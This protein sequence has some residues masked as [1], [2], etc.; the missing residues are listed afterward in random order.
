MA[1]ELFPLLKRLKVGSYDNCVIL[2]YTAD[3]YFFEQVVL[4]TLRSR[5]SCNNLV[6]MDSRQYVSALDTSGTLLRRLGKS[7]SVWPVPAAQAFHPKLLLQTSE[8]QARLIVGSGNLTVRGFSTNWELFSEIAFN[9]ESENGGLF[10]EAWKLISESAKDTTTAVRRQLDRMQTTSGSALSS[11]GG[12]TWPRLLFAAPS[13]PS[14]LNQL[15]ALIGKAKV[16][17]LIIV[18]PFFDPKLQAVREFKSAFGVK[19]VLAIVQPESVSFPGKMAKT[20][21]NLAVHEFVP[22]LGTKSGYLHAK[23]FV[24]QTPTTEYTVWGSANCSMSALAGRGNYEAVLVTR[25]KVGDGV[26]TLGLG[27]SIK[28]GRKI[29]PA[30]LELAATQS[31][32][33]DDVLSLTSA[34]VDQGSIRVVISPTDRF[35]KCDDGRLRLRSE[36][37]PLGEIPVRRADDV[38]FTGRLNR[39]EGGSVICRFVLQDE[40]GE[41]E[42]TPVAVHFLQDLEE[43]TPTRLQA[44]MQR[45]VKA[46]QLGTFEWAKGLESVCELVIKIGLHTD[47]ERPTGKNRAQ[48]AKKQASPTDTD[49]EAK[50][51]EYEDFVS[52]ADDDRRKEKEVESQNA[53][54]DIVS[55]LRAQILRGV[56]NEDDEEGEV[57]DPDAWRYREEAEREAAESGA[58]ETQH[59]LPDSEALEK[60]HLRVRRGY[61]Q[62]VRGLTRRYEWLRDYKEAV[63]TEEFWRLDAVNLLLLDGCG[64]YIERAQDLGAV[65]LPEDVIKQYLPAAAVFLGRVRELRDSSDGNGPLLDRAKIE[66]SDAGIRNALRTS[67]A[68][69]TGVVAH[70]RQLLMQPT[71]DDDA[72]NEWPHYTEIVAA[73]CLAAIHRYQL[74]PTEKELSEEASRS[75]WLASIERDTLVNTYEDLCRLARSIVRCEDQFAAEQLPHSAQELTPGD[76]V[77]SAFTG[78]TEVVSVSDSNIEIA[79]I[80][81]PDTAEEWFRIVKSDCLRRTNIPTKVHIKCSSVAEELDHLVPYSDQDFEEWRDLIMPQLQTGY[82]TSLSEVSH[83]A[84]SSQLRSEASRLLERNARASSLRPPPDPKVAMSKKEQQE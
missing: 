35:S 74:L 76:W 33:T 12:E 10:A 49:E 23:A 64:R 47:A 54:E 58:S 22:P 46:I 61:V 34:E 2:T 8:K 14:L 45:V 69:L 50:V 71:F 77:C 19:D 41:Q 13:Q 17:R 38:T 6:I 65:L 59:D 11:D 32:R 16:R 51:G 39:S 78:V 1:I 15:G 72:L 43:A 67:C 40:A 18:A 82:L 75:T 73:R 56:T 21:K 55:T 42:S 29:E 48:R 79:M 9:T 63:E 7:Y 20:V 31:S 24:I 83:R 57:G 36:G 25:S 27:E 52:D 84:R 66:Q 3:L 28:K 26:A 60:E 80:G 44:Q 81:E 53:L 68:L 4:P 37:K 5:G 30:D 70:W 62:L